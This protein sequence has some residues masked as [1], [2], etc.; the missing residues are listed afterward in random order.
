MISSVVEPNA[1]QIG[2]QYQAE[3]RVQMTDA[4]DTEVTSSVMGNSGLYEQTIRLID[5]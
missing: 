2:K 5:G 1:F 4:S 3:R